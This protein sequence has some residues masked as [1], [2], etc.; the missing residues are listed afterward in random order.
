MRNIYLFTKKFAA[1]VLLFGLGLS[2]IA[3]VTEEEFSDLHFDHATTKAELNTVKA[4]LAALQVTVNNEIATLTAAIAAL[5]AQDDEIM[6][7]LADRFSLLKQELA[8]AVAALAAADEA[9]LVAALAEVDRVEDEIVALMQENIDQLKLLVENLSDSL[10][11]EINVAIARAESLVN[12]AIA[13]AANANSALAEVVAA[14]EAAAQAANDAL[15]LLIEENA[16]AIEVLQDELNNLDAYVEDLTDKQILDVENLKA[17]IEALRAELNSSQAAQDADYTARL[18]A[19]ITSVS[20]AIAKADG[21]YAAALIAI[22]QGDNELADALAASNRAIDARIAEINEALAAQDNDRLDELI[23]ALEEQ[24]IDTETYRGV[25]DRLFEEAGYTVSGNT[26]TKAEAT[27]TVRDTDF[28]LI[29]D[30]VNISIGNGSRLTGSAQDDFD[31][32]DSAVTKR[33][34]RLVW[35]PLTDI[36]YDKLEWVSDTVIDGIYV[37]TLTGSVTYRLNDD[38]DAFIDATID[39]VTYTDIDAAIAAAEAFELPVELSTVFSLGGAVS[40]T[41]GATYGVQFTLTGNPQTFQTGVTIEANFTDTPFFAQGGQITQGG[42]YVSDELKTITV[43]VTHEDY[44]GFVTTTVDNPNYKPLLSESLTVTERTTTGRYP[45]FINSTVIPNVASNVSITVNGTT[46]FVSTGGNVE[47]LN[48][49]ETELSY[50]ITAD[51]YRGEVTGT[52]DNPNYVESSFTPPGTVFFDVNVEYT[53]DFSQY[54]VGDVTNFRWTHYYNDAN[55]DAMA[56]SGQGN[57]TG[58]HGLDTDKSLQ[59]YYTIDGVEEMFIILLR[60]N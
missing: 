52:F 35:D 8:Q 40:S 58:N 55:G 46:P 20:N 59:V 39:G 13:I 34:N 2:T 60:S 28:I 48:T 9:N 27:I 57:F 14:N 54:A 56:T 24:M 43:T 31:T 10:S 4:D 11:A 16:A 15:Q 30:G 7:E 5:Q 1:I 22:Q 33:L 32:I 6:A 19:I 37:E 21:Q 3:C 38:T 41:P 12:N 44:E 23:A 42:G 18:G 29:V 25:L 51:G 45:L 53:I 50:T 17:L 36:F 49:T 26:I 47:Y